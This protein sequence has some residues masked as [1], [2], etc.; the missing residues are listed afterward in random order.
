MS[1][2]LPECPICRCESVV[3]S[4]PCIYPPAVEIDPPATVVAAVKIGRGML[5]WIL[6]VGFVLGLFVAQLLFAF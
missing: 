4:R 6:L 5:G 3:E 2:C 1:D